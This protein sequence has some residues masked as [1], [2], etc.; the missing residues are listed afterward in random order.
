MLEPIKESTCEIY[1]SN[2]FNK[3]NHDCSDHDMLS[4]NKTNSINKE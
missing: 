4:D 1:E 3:N 2:N